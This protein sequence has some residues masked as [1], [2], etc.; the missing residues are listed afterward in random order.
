MS[1]CDKLLSLFAQSHVHVFTKQKNTSKFYDNKKPSLL[2]KSTIFYNDIN[3]K[4][5]FIIT[6]KTFMYQTKSYDTD[7]I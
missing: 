5:K 2:H 7:W 1:Q 3:I 6:M 4:Y